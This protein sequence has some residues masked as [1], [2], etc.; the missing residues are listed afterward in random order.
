MSI[1]PVHEKKASPLIRDGADTHGQPHFAT[2]THIRAFDALK[3]VTVDTCIFKM[4]TVTQ[5]RAFEAPMSVTFDT[6]KMQVS[7]VTHSRASNAVKCVTVSI[8]KM[9]VST[10]T[11]FR[12]S[13]V[14]KSVTVAKCGR[15]GV[16]V[17][18]SVAQEDLTKS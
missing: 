8:L 15:V 5:F 2:V 12:A 6:L 11:H 14:P 3:C 13:N 10:V 9:Q 1:D 17:I 7:T 18:V 16:W 4:L